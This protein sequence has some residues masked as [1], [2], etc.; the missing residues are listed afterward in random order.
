MRLVHTDKVEV[1]AILAK[2]IVNEREQVLLHEGAVL[3]DHMLA[4]LK[5]LGIPVIY[6]KNHVNEVSELDRAISEELRKKTKKIIH[7]TFEKLSKQ[8]TITGGSIVLESSSKEFIY[9]IRAI[10]DEI[11]EHNV[12]L[13]LISNIFIV[14][15]YIFRHSFNV[16]LHSIA[17]GLKLNLSSKQ[18]ELLGLGAIFHDIGKLKVPQ[19]ILMKPGKLTEE[20]F[21]EMKKHTEY[22]FSILKDVKAV[23]LIV[24]HCAYQHHERLDGTGYPRGLKDTDIQYFA[25]IIAVADVFDALTSNRVYRNAM[26]PHE[27]L[28]I[29]YAGC[30]QLFDLKIVEAF[31]ST[32]AFYP[33]GATVELSNRIIGIVKK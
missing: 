11:Q 33:V 21:A 3:T 2:S 5:E 6:I 26:L 24:A 4:R 32:V 19:E 23:P 18:L 12:L 31:R 25:K 9:I 17:I 27:G 7:D 15:D 16:T 28:E 1:G 30:G 13:D 22:G 10:L 29:L 14:D 20:E 8:Q